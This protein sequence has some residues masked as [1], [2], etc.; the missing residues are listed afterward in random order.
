[1]ALKTCRLS[2]DGIE[3]DFLIDESERIIS[4]NVERTGVWEQNQLCL[5]R[6]FIPD[7]GV[8]VDIGAN[9]GVNAIFA[10]HRVPSAR[11][12]AVE[13]SHENFDVLRQNVEETGIEVHHLAI[14]DRDG[15]IGFAGS[16]TDAHISEDGV[17]VPCKT[18]DSFTA[19]FEKIDLL[20]IDVEGFTD[21]VLASS[22]ETLSKTERAIIEFSA[23]D[24]EKRF[25]ADFD[26]HSHF[27]ELWDR[28]SFPHIYYIS[29]RDGLVSVSGVGDVIDLLSI[30]F[31]VGDLLFSRR[32]SPAISVSSFTLRRVKELMAQNHTRAT[33]IAWL[34]ERVA[35]L[36]NENH[37]RLSE[38]SQLQEQ[39]RELKHFRI[40]VRKSLG[41]NQY[42]LSELT[43][44]IQ[45]MASQAEGLHKSAATI[46][47]MQSLIQQLQAENHHRLTEAANLK[48]DLDRIPRWVRRLPDFGRR[49]LRRTPT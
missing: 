16:G 33:D 23:V 35:E 3:F 8:M 40:D 30:E 4:P 18:L 41:D 7:N 32:E 1:M 22:S 45:K 9:V 13:A 27:A 34:R 43:P 38:A 48:A 47:Q 15:T 26:V 44:Q 5:Y 11:I 21:L 24:I 28:I 29:R 19:A 37:H 12:V 31:S 10:H 25:G 20:K 14:A 42:P 39:V 36:Q 46:E 2:Y 17:D 6:G 49:K